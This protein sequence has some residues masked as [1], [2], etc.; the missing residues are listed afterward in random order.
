MT[1]KENTSISTAMLTEAVMETARMEPNSS[2]VNSTTANSKMQSVFD[3]LPC[4]KDNAIDTK[5]LVQFAGCRSSR[6]LQNLIAAERA[7]GK[8]ILSSSKGGYFKPA[9]GRQGR[10]EINDF[11]KT[12]RARALHTLAAL[13]SAQTVIGEVDGQLDLA[14]LYEQ[15]EV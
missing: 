3:L 10:E 12:L 13:K 2:Q 8:L 7:N 9:P 6:D 11:I 15:V 1:G 4:G 14:D 5:T